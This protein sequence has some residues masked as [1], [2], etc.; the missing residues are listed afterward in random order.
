VSVLKVKGSEIQQ[1]TTEL[2]MGDRPVRS[3]YDVHGDD[4]S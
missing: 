4:G 1:A 3:P 2:L